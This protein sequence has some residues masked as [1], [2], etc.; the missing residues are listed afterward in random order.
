MGHPI[1][2]HFWWATKRQIKPLFFRRADGLD[3][4]PTWQVT[5][6]LYKM[7]SWLHKEMRPK[8]TEII[9]ERAE[10]VRIVLIKPPEELE[11]FTKAST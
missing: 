5:R 9:Y 8:L 7:M 10:H 1:H 3:G 6:R 11:A 4:R 2:V